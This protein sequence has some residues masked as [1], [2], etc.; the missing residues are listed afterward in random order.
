[1]GTSGLIAPDAAAACSRCAKKPMISSR[2]AIV[3]CPA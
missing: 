2:A 1:M 3:G